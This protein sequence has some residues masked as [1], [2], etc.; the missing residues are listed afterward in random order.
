MDEI[1]DGIIESLDMSLS[2]LQEFMMDREPGVLQ[3][4]GLQRVGHDRVTETMAEVMKIMVTS[5][6]RSHAG[7]AIL[8]SP[9]PAEGHH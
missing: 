7:T 8:S 3:S 9:S 4:T 2:E 1:V 5:F 6:G